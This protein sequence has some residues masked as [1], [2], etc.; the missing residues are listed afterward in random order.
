MHS[1]SS[2]TNPYATVL[3]VVCRT[4]SA[5]D[6]D[7]MISAYGF[8]GPPAHVPSITHSQEKLV[9]LI[10]AIVWDWTVWVQHSRVAG[11]CRYSEQR[12]GTV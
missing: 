3:S 6:D 4:L 8:G 12:Q 7:Q 11:V 2:G 9:K 5:F 1:L 10:P